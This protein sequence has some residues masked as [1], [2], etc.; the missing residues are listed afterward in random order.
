[1]AA[2]SPMER[3]TNGRA[4]GQKH[5]ERRCPFRSGQLSD[6]RSCSLFCKQ[7][8]GGARLLGRRQA[9]DNQVRDEDLASVAII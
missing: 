4:G 5:G 8:T 9:T 3:Y 6:T 2:T 1:M 7:E